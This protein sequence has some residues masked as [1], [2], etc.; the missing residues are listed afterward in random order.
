MLSCATMGIN[1][2]EEHDSNH[3]FTPAEQMEYLDRA[4][5][6]LPATGGR[7]IFLSWR[8]LGTDEPGILFDIVKDG[9]TIKSD[10]K[11]SN[12]TDTK[13][14]KTSSYEIVVKRDG[15]EVERTKAFTPWS[16]TFLRQTLD[17]PA[18]GVTPAGESY[19]YTPNDCSVGDVDGDGQYE[20]IVKWDPSNSKDNSQKGYTGNVYL[21]AYKLDMTSEKPTK[22]WRIDLGVNIRAGAHYTQF[23]VY[24]FNGDGKAEMM[25]KT[26]PGSKDGSGESCCA[27]RPQCRGDGTDRFPTALPECGGRRIPVLFS[28][29]PHRGRRARS[30][31]GHA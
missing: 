3:F 20:L 2:T 12:F 5:V 28:D 17:R 11:V 13:G 15:K 8:I 23:L 18:D 30:S 7:G 6:A 29:C 4:P 24:D 27:A 16:K 25:C 14:T 9:T 31:S 22:L 26:A 19:S 1:A 10:S 21:D